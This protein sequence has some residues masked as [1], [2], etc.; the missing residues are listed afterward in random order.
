[1]KE[2]TPSLFTKALKAHLWNFGGGK[3]QE[4]GSELSVLERFSKGERKRK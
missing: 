4:K 3:M 2:A 1:M